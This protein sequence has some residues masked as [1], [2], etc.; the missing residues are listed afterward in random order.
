[1][2]RTTEQTT[3][4][5]DRNDEPIEHAN[6]G[7]GVEQVAEVVGRGLQ[8]KKRQQKDNKKDQK[9]EKKRQKKRKEKRQS[10]Y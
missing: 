2:C 10:C 4:A 6:A 3:A 9:K 8:E 5:D 7:Y 1:L